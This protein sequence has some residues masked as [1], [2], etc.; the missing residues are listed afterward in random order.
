MQ[1]FA[2]LLQLNLPWTR[3][4]M[5]HVAWANIGYKSTNILLRQI[6]VSQLYAARHYIKKR[7]LSM[8][9]DEERF[10]LR[11]IYTLC[12]LFVFFYASYSF[13]VPSEKASHIIYF[14]LNLSLS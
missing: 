1:Q 11:V 8:L 3:F 6:A 14:T 9:T 4:G 13:H 10:I 2:V 5:C 7:D 12:A